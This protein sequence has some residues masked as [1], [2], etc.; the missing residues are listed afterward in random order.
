MLVDIHAN[1]ARVPS[2]WQ[3]QPF[4]GQLQHILK[5][6]LPACPSLNRSDPTLKDTSVILLAGIRTCSLEEH[7]DLGL[8][9]RF[10]SVTG[11]F[12]VVDMNSVQCLIGRVQD[13]GRYAIV[14]RTS[15]Q[16][17]AEYD[18]RE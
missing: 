9:F 18:D 11:G 1:N 6:Q 15:S 10:Y 5:V 3:K 14:D 13:R 17:E 12:E 2:Q 16:N 8:N 4:F 7:D